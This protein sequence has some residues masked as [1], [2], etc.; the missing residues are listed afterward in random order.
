M[1]Q[2]GEVITE[3]GASHHMMLLVD[4]HHIVPCPVSFADGSQVMATKSG[5]LRLSEKLKLD[6]VLFVPNLNC[7]LL[8]VAKLLR[9]TG[10]LAVFTDTL[11]ILQD[12][13]TRTLIG[14]SEVKDGV[15]VYREVTVARVTELK[16]QR[17]R[18]CGI[19]V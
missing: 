18:L 11:C 12:R 10:C 19:V 5:C 8:F 6:H 7:T 1:I 3:T 9:Q 2:S 17:I 14:A 15:Y 4:V 13:F 16:L